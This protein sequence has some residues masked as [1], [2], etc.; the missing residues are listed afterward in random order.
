MTWQGGGMPRTKWNA[1]AYE[2]N[3]A[4][5]PTLGLNALELLDPKPSERILDLGCGD[6]VLTMELDKR[7]GQ[8]VAIDGSAEMVEAARARGIDARTV[9]ASRLVDEVG[10]GP[11]QAESFDAVFSNAAL[12]W[13]PQAADVIAGV[14]ALLKPEGRFVAEFGGHGNV[15]AF[16]VALDAA[17]RLHGFEAT[18]GPWFFPTPD[19]YANLLAEGGFDVE[20]IALIP[21][22]TLLPT[23]AAGWMRTFG[24]P[25]LSDLS[26]AHADAVAATAIELLAGAL[27]D[28][29]GHW[30][31]DYVRLRFSAHRR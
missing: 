26:A 11:M 30:T 29:S 3:A 5:V 9:D 28:V 2:D 7:A 14:Q 8:I 12:H 15:A 19:E 25:Y 13:I 24:G 10:S 23:G 18:T 21:R 22:P 1:K 16:T 6:G 17:R 4:F 20:S 31:A 27:R